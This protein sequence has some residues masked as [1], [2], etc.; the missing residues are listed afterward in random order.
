MCVQMGSLSG[1]ERKFLSGGTM[2]LSIS[3]LLVFCNCLLFGQGPNDTRQTATAK[4]RGHWQLQVVRL[5]VTGTAHLA[6]PPISVQ[7]NDAPANP[8]LWYANS[9]D[10]PSGQVL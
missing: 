1:S 10:I 9:F 6:N 7:L 2:K 4:E 3:F 8:G 5:Q